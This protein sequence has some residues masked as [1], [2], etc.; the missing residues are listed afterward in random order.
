MHL[1]VPLGKWK[2]KWIK[3]RDNLEDWGS[4]IL[5]PAIE[6]IWNSESGNTASSEFELNSG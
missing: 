3:N 2:K 4:N 6:A 5:K 1:Q